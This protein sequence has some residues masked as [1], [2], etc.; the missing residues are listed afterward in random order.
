MRDGIFK[1]LPMPPVWR[2]LL[3]RC[4]READRGM[5]DEEA[6]KD[7]LRHDLRAGL[8]TSGINALRKLLRDTQGMFPGFGELPFAFGDALHQSALERDIQ[9]QLARHWA[10]G[11]SGEHLV[12]SA[13]RATLQRCSDQFLR[14]FE[15]HLG[16]TDRAAATATLAAAKAACQAAIPLVT[17]EVL[18]LAAPVRTARQKIDLDENLLG[19]RP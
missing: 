13:V 5:R 19:G 11:N 1:S 7:A 2:R 14:Q 16:P 4:D 8:T 12:E 10:A 3:R 18:G 17:Q 6:A 9:S 15:Q